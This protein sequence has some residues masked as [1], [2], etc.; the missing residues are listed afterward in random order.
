MDGG[1]VGYDLEFGNPYQNH[2]SKNSDRKPNPQLFQM[3][4]AADCP[5]PRLHHDQTT[6]D[7]IYP[8]A[9]KPAASRPDAPA[10]R[11][12]Y[13]RYTAGVMNADRAPGRILAKRKT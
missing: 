5:K 4:D 6:N 8:A 2:A 1:T 7:E 3:N 9:M 11:M 13:A 10:M 12:V